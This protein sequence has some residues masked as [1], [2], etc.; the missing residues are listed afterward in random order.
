MSRFLALQAST[1]TPQVSVLQLETVQLDTTAARL[2]NLLLPQS[3]LK[4]VSAQQGTT[5]LLVQA[6]PSP[7]PLVSTILPLERQQR[8]I[9]STVLLER[10]VTL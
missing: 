3:L 7:A 2:Q 4:E 8:Q 9:V 1:V 10:C 6:S 5:A